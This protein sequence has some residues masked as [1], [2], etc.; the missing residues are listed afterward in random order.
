M[1]AA[2]KT[3]GTEPSPVEAT[4]PQCDKA[5]KAIETGVLEKASPSNKVE[6]K[7]APRRFFE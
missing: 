3:S 5:S 1:S 7:L 6:Q 2:L 4:N